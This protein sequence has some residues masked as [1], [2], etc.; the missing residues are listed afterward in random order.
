MLIVEREG[1][2]RIVRSGVLDP[3]PIHGTPASFQNA[4]NGLKDLAL[5]PD[6]ETNHQ[7]YLLISEGNFE[8]HHAAVFRAHYS[9]AG[10]VD[11]TRIFRSSEELG[12][13]GPAAARMLFL[14]DKTLIVAVPED[15]FHKQAAQKLSSDIGKIVRIRR[16]GSIPGDNPLLN[17]PNARPEIWSY[18][19]RVP[20]GLYRDPQTGGIWEVE[21]GPMGGDELNWLKPGGN[22]GWA[23][24]SWGFDYG[25][26][27]ASPLQVAPGI[28]QPVLIWMPWAPPASPTPAGITRYRGGRYPLWDGDFFVGFLAGKAIERVRMVGRTV[29]LQEKMLLDLEERIRDVKVGPDN[30][31]YVLTDHPNGRLLRLNSGEPQRDELKRVAHKLQQAWD[32]TSDENSRNTYAKLLPGN[33]IKGKQ[34]F[35]ERC[36]ACH[37]VGSLVH[38]GKLG[39][40]L[41][42]V[43]GR[44]AGTLPGF[45]YSAAL[46]GSPQN[47]DPFAINLFIADPGN[48]APGTSMTAPPVEDEGVRREIVGFLVQAS[49]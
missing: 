2:L 29:V 14:P 31:L 28:E 44:R 49:E 8:Q 4:Y 46:A 39:P 9:P 41:R 13:V 17:T 1:G 43:I 34:A 6:F 24:A 26:G 10:L 36:S 23:Q 33:P 7:L 30:Y 45:S 21:P 25:G 19:H 18:G 22:F 37:S 27:L 15:N 42:G 47:W 48:Y 11:V 32:P 35:L 3:Q 16:D 38:G 40:D 12:G 20:T 5:D